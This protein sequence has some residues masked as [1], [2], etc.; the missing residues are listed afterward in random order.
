[1]HL[2]HF[3]RAAQSSRCAEISVA[4]PL[5]VTDREE[6]LAVLRS[7]VDLRIIATARRTEKKQVNDNLITWSSLDRIPTVLRV[8]TDV[9][10][11]I[12]RCKSAVL[13]LLRTMQCS[14]VC[15]CHLMPTASWPLFFR[16]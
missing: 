6:V 13:L 16:A 9:M 3:R 11:R 2:S 1:M 12:W 8:D 15:A 14:V 7:P 10:C 4:F 5:R